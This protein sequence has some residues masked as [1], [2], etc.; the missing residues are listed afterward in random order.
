M[1]LL[2]IAEFADKAG[3]TPQAIYK[4]IKTDLAAYVV[5][6]NGFN[7]I[8]AEALML[9]NHTQAIK[10]ESKEKELL[11]RVQELE[12]LV[13]TLTQDKISL[14]TKAAEDKE[15]LWQF[16]EKL[17]QMQ[18]NFQVLL[19]QTNQVVLSLKQSNE[20]EVEEPTEVEEVE[21]NSNKPSFFQKLFKRP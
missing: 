12:E 6:E 16:A 9:F 7:R 1:E 3:V 21:N 17:A 8:D 14:L 11:E 18:E 20:T 19:A 10:Q 15:K 5:V 13:E 4:R 2:S